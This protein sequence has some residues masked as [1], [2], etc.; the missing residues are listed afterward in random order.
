MKWKLVSLVYLA[1][2]FDD[3]DEMLYG[4]QKKTLASTKFEGN[5]LLQIFHEENKA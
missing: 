5:F 3:F 2:Y 1:K 4:S